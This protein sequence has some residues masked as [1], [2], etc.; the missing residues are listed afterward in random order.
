MEATWWPAVDPGGEP[1]SAYFAWRVGGPANY[2]P[3][4]VSEASSYD[5]G[6]QHGATA[7]FPSGPTRR[8]AL[9]AMEA[10]KQDGV[11]VVL[12]VSEN[13]F[14][15]PENIMFMVW[16]EEG[17]LS[18]RVA[19][20]LR[21]QVPTRAEFEQAFEAQLGLHREALEIADALAV[22]T[23]ALLDAYS[24]HPGAYLCPS[25]IDPDQWPRPE[26]PDDG[27]FRV[28][29]ALGP[30][31]GDDLALVVDAL[32]WAASQDAVELV[33]IGIDPCEITWRE[34]NRH[35][36]LL[37]GSPRALMA[38]MERPRLSGDFRQAF[39]E[40]VSNLYKAPDNFL[41]RVERRQ[42]AWRFPF[43]RVPFVS[44]YAAFKRTLAELDVV[45]CPVVE[46]D[47]TVCRADTRP[48][49]AAMVAALPIVSEGIVYADWG[50][51]YVEG[52]KGPALVAESAEGFCSRLAWAVENRDEVRALGQEARDYVLS[53]R[54]IENT[55]ELWRGACPAPARTV[56]A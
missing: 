46:T 31:Q 35:T 42:Q 34:F 36:E 28:G 53:E 50:A 38:E 9:R 23:P 37:R 27:V 43:R 10:A 15:T 30:S 2:F 51:P 56:A 47:W 45:L 49:E 39:D 40:R 48:L 26:K 52:R 41:A 54:T 6:Q 8:E 21:P 32:R 29:L 17:G 20:F 25:A 24:F 12:D 14:A 5:P 4:V 33:V 1:S 22:T 55:I 44:D 16:K 3:G 13:C 19:D 11:R 18:P 7:F